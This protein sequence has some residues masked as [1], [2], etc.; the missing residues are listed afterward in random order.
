MLFIPLASIS[1]DGLKKTRSRTPSGELK[2]HFPPV[3]AGRTVNVGDEGSNKQRTMN[4]RV[5]FSMS[6]KKKPRPLPS[7]SKSSGQS[8][9]QQRGSPKKKPRAPLSPVKN[10]ERQRAKQ[11][12]TESHKDGLVSYGKKQV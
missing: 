11:E 12:I 10:G 7:P 9:K 2:D 4:K 8:A 6:P 3:P 1:G 5:C